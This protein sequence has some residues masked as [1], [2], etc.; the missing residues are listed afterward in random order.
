MVLDR[1]QLPPTA[2]PSVQASMDEEEF[3]R[4]S[5]SYTEGRKDDYETQDG[6]VSYRSGSI[7]V[8]RGTTVTTNVDNGLPRVHAIHYYHNKSFHSSLASCRT[9]TATGV[10]WHRR[11]ASENNLS[12]TSTSGL[13]DPTRGANWIPDSPQKQHSK[14]KKLIRVRN[15]SSRVFCFC[16]SLLSAPCLH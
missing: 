3:S 14:P 16:Q 11:S 10:T 12:R 9:P 5:K 1:L 15:K 7:A 4:A 8:S 6:S 2:L 13:H